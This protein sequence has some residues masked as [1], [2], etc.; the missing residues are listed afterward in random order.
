MRA[1]TALK[2]LGLFVLTVLFA[3]VAVIH[4]VDV[5][6]YKAH[7]VTGMEKAIGRKVAIAGEV[8]LALSLSPALVMTD[9]AVGN[10]PW[11]SRPDMA[12][13][14]RL[15]IQMA[16]VPLLAGVVKVERLVL[17]EPDVLLETDAQGQDNWRIS[18]HGPTDGADPV[19]AVLAVT[20]VRLR[21]GKVT[22]RDAGGGPEGVAVIDRLTADAPHPG[23]PVAVSV[24]GRIGSTPIEAKGTV[25]SED[26]TYSVTG[27]DAAVGG[28]D[29]K[30]SLTVA[31]RSSPPLVTALL[32][33]S[34]IDLDMPPSG[35]A[36]MPADPTRLFPDDP[37]PMAGLKQV[38]ADI[39]LTVGRVT[40][41]GSTI[42]DVAA[43]LSLKGGRLVVDLSR[44]E[45]GGGKLSGQ[46]S[47]EPVGS[48]VAAVKVRMEGAPVDLG[49]VLKDAGVTGAFTGGPVE[50]KVALS[51][52]GDSVRS[53]MAALSGDAQ[54]SLG[55]GRLDGT[56][57][58]GA[59]RFAQVLT[60]M[61]PRLRSQSDI[62][63]TCGLVRLAFR[64]GIASTDRGIAIETTKLAAVGG[65]TLDLK[66]ETL[67]LGLRPSRHRTADALT[68]VV[69]LRGPLAEPAV[70]LDEAGAARTV[71]SVVA[72][73]IPAL[74]QALGE[75]V[76]AANG[77][78]CLTALT[79]AAKPVVKPDK[80]RKAK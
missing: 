34:H 66:T 3:V 25:A 58:E 45:W 2:V 18:P 54:A 72:G 52:R 48:G 23:A 68:G 20:G 51:G 1:G 74:G 73:S 79:G 67:D 56:A 40:R 19:P 63:V 13:V 75:R 8:K 60:S 47:V 53:V 9:V 29:F 65:G 7:V 59:G 62:E 30:G 61:N 50:L 46:M 4:S 77:N 44:A 31:T 71:A 14:R 24:V 42:G 35:P 39:G 49:R 69:R 22:W 21:A 26:G 33:S 15:E 78:S 55:P 76:N 64:D 80:A 6:R 27:L 12:T 43:K 16:L 57:V 36:P 70:A 17:I 38:N 5:N 37:L 11:G 28:G 41:R 32:S 10:A